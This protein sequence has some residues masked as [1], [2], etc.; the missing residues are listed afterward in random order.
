M[1]DTPAPTPTPLADTDVA[2]PTA[3]VDL[4]AIERDLT[5]VEVA[6]GR[7]AEGTYWTDEITG[8]P[9]PDSVLALDPT[10]RRA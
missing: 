2:T 7:L 5:A 1:S 10:A 9:L 6:L 8:Q 3:D 4:D